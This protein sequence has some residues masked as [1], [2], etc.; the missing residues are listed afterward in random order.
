M[1]VGYNTS[2]PFICAGNYLTPSASTGV[3]RV[4]FPGV[5][6]VRVIYESG[7]PQSALGS[8]FYSGGKTFYISPLGLSG[9]GS[10]MGVYGSMTSC[11]TI[12]DENT[13]EY[14]EAF[15][16]TTGTKVSATNVW[17]SAFSVLPL[18]SDGDRNYV[19][20][21]MPTLSM[22]SGN[23]KSPSAFDMGRDGLHEP[24]TMVMNENTVSAFVKVPS[25]S[26]IS[27]QNFA[28]N[29]RNLSGLYWDSRGSTAAMGGFFSD[30][31]LVST[32]IFNLGTA[33]LDRFAYAPYDYKYNCIDTLVIRAESASINSMFDNLYG[34][35]GYTNNS[36]CK[37]DFKCGEVVGIDVGYHSS[38]INV[39]CANSILNRFPD[40]YYPNYSGRLSLLLFNCSHTPGSARIACPAT[41]WEDIA[42]SCD[43]LEQLELDFMHASAGCS[44]VV[45]FCTSLKDIEVKNFE[46]I[47]G[48]VLDYDYK[49]PAL[50]SFCGYT[51]LKDA[52]DYWSS[53][54]R[55]A[56]ASADG[57]FYG[58]VA[59]PDYAECT[60]SP[61]YSAWTTRHS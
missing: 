9:A 2:T 20:A 27:A 22:L 39:F 11:A 52:I 55:T 17:P 35:G 16:Y 10:A 57:M 54:C 46:N 13:L 36:V 53:N 51:S 34:T 8:A 56:S 25:G 18:T 59:F 60:A 31:A 1:I 19:V 5:G 6:R 29:V 24:C 49:L 50:T 44:S 38:T 41:A 7:Y 33:K 32:A 43:S 45:T 30:S 21:H 3:P 61:V 14:G 12:I 37:C 47:S 58:C 15:V 28:K 4:D 48:D 23:G 42:V 40:F 26:V